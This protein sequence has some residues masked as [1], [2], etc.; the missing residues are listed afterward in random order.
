MT[1]I[2][3]IITTFPS[4]SIQSSARRLEP[5]WPSRRPSGI[6]TLRVTVEIGDG[7]F[8]NSGRTGAARAM[9]LRCSESRAPLPRLP[10][11]A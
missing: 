6:C 2:P 4:R 9:A 8:C 11:S 5:Q 1:T 3:S 7:R 10:E